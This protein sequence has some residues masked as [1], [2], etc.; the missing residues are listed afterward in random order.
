MSGIDQRS[1]MQFI[2]TA[3][4]KMRKASFWK[5]FTLKKS[6]SPGFFSQARVACKK[7]GSRG[8]APRDFLDEGSRLSSLLF[9]ISSSFLVSTKD[10]IF[11]QIHRTA[12]SHLLQLNDHSGW[13]KFFLKPFTFFT[14]PKLLAPLYNNLSSLRSQKK[15]WD[16]WLVISEN[17]SSPS[18]FS[19]F[20]QYLTDCSEIDHLRL[21]IVFDIFI[22]S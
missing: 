7:G 13:K 9:P 15:W 4:Q 20:S 10:P 22:I 3:E 14:D 5:E 18:S 17:C 19:A 16:I 8:S 21:K 12:Q 11:V 2:N 6:V 1:L